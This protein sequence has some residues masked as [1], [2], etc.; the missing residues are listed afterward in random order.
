MVCLTDLFATCSEILGVDLIEDGAEDSISFLDAALGKPANEGH[1]RTEMVNH[2]N[3]GEFAFRDGPWKLVFKN[4]SDNLEESREKETF[5]ELYHLGEDI[6]ETTNVAEDRPGVLAKMRA[7]LK[8]LIN[9][10]TSRPGQISYN[11]TAVRFE[12]T[13]KERWGE[14][15][16]LPK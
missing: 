10:G 13:Q 12:T 1:R 7:Q 2:S 6:A 16:K 5:P 14:P 11:D 4:R 15:L 8:L 3:H 9:F